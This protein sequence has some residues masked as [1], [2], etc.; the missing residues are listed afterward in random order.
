M[1]YELINPPGQLLTEFWAF[2]PIPASEAW[3]PGENWG[4]VYNLPIEK[5]RDPFSQSAPELNF[6]VLWFEYIFTQESNTQDSK[7]PSDLGAAKIRSP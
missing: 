7:Q 1:E 6:E 2:D 4:E 5:L 3:F